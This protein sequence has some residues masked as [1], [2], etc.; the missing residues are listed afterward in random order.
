MQTKSEAREILKLDDIKLL[1]D[2]FYDRVR[3]DEFLAPIFEEKLKDKWPK[4]LDIMYRFWQTILLEEHTYQ[5]SPFVKH[6]GL[7]VDK[8]HFQRWIAIFYK[9]V[10]DLFTGK[11]AT[12]AKWRADRMAEMFAYKLEYFKNT[13]GA[14]Q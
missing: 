6:V 1:V 8:A 7:P 9:T 10:D 2:T 11:I 3:K 14:I 12:E 5:G 4:H 13:P